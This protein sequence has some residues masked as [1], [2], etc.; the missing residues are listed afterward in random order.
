MGERL[1]DRHLPAL[2]RHGQAVC[3]ELNRVV[4]LGRH[5]EAWLHSFFFQFLVG[6]GI[7]IFFIGLCLAVFSLRATRSRE[8]GTSPL[9]ASSRALSS[10]HGPPPWAPA[11]EASARCLPLGGTPPLPLP[12]SRTGQ[13]PQLSLL[14]LPLTVFPLIRV[15]AKPE[16]PFLL[17]REVFYVGKRIKRKNNALVFEAVMCS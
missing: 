10:A 11:P 9:G 2:H 13:E 14:W 3:S 8:R 7:C 15:L 6:L 5:R 16:L 17:L 4:N 1:S 12:Y